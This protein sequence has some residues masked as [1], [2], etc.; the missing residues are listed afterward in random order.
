MVAETP[1]GQRFSLRISKAK[2]TAPFI[3]FYYVAAGASILI[4]GDGGCVMVVHSR[5]SVLRARRGFTLVE[6]LVVIAIIG[7]LVALLLP[8]IQAAREAARRTQCKNNLHQIAL[9]CLN[10]E[11]THKVFPY[12]GWS[13]GWMG[14]PDQGIGPQQPGGWI[15]SMSPYLEEGA[16]FHLGGGLPWDDKKVALSDQMSHVSS[17]FICPSRRAA[18][19]YPA[20]SPSGKSCDGGNLPRNAI[21]P[22]LVAKTDYVIN[23]GPGAPDFAG[24]S[25]G[26]PTADCLQSSANAV[27]PDVTD[28]AKY[29]DCNFHVKNEKLPE[30]K[31]RF[32]G[33]SA[34]RMAAKISQ[35]IDGTSQ[36]LLVGEKRMQPRFYEDICDRDGPPCSNSNPSRGNGGDNNSMYQGYDYDNS[37]TGNPA[38]DQDIGNTDC[39]D[40]GT[41]HESFGSPHTGGV[42]IAYCDGSVQT[43]NYD[44]DED[45]WGE[46]IKRNNASDF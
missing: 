39:N 29:P 35:I 17:T 25:G 11:S 2:E 20:Y 32:A 27:D 21:L 19:G 43:I 6:L 44:I 24:G 7:I 45:V 46:K 31:A 1:F 16:V 33:V 42:N 9:G 4:D 22:S 23:N 10:H 30:L 37:R 12:G 38:L 26:A 36:T 41:V 3:R 13:F 40:G 34:F 5:L 8:A 14:D 18:I 28:A 15:Y